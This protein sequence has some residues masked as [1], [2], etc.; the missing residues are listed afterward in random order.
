MTPPGGDTPSY[1]GEIRAPGGE[2]APGT[3]TLDDETVILA[4]DG[5]LPRAIPYRDLAVI[6]ITDLVG[7]VATGDGPAAERWLLQRFGAA[8][9][10]LVGTLRERR[11]R[12]RVADALVALPESEPVELVE[13]V[14]EGRAAGAATPERGIAQL[15][16]DGWGV[17]LAPL[18]E[19]L[20]ALRV[21][22]AEIE[23]VALLPQVGG[24]RVAASSG[25]FDLLRLG[26]AAARH[27]D[28]LA[29]LPRTARL[30]AAAI[31]ARL[32]PDLQPA[33]ASRAAEALVDG[34]P[35]SPADLG[36]S[37]GPLERGVLGEPTFEASYL[38]LR[39]RAG[40]PGALRWLAL[41][42]ERPGDPAHHRAWFL[43]ALPGNLVALEL[44]SE[45]AH[46][47]YC[48]RAAPRA[49]FSGG[50]GPAGID[51]AAASRAVARVS[52]A[53]VDARFLREP[54]ALPDDRLATP[55]AIR[56]RLAL[57]AI[58]SLAAARSEFVARLVHRDQAS[59]SAALDA[60]IAWHAACRDD[61][62]SWPGRVAQEA[63]VGEAAGGGAAG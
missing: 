61:A 2:T 58:P 1:A 10:P 53:L 15:A 39:E 50:A 55:E 11:L 20:E 62:A 41:A 52:A 57:R 8:I 54:I 33:V 51:A 27:R 6:A 22:R 4:P 45:G 47:T 13:Y 60:L 14:R 3:V 36:E 34:R 21:R 24:V 25:G 12:Q 44:V 35:G 16:V 32:A 43:V 37:W 46:A 23:T 59:W 49:T 48:F 40:G 7:L 5:G 38:A 18:D 42:P 63:A 56:Y 29:A 28:R 19:R 17:T 9:G 31:L 30:D 26:A